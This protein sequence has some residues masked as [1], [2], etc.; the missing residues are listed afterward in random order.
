MDFVGG[1]QVTTMPSLILSKNSLQN[2]TLDC[3]SLGIHYQV[4]TTDNITTLRRW[5]GRSGPDTYVDIG[6]WEHRIF[7]KNT[8][9]LRG[10][11]EPVIVSELFTQTSSK[12]SGG[13]YL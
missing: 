11:S 13:M 8:F 7:K 1:T 2:T 10:E 9:K 5:D 6:Q 4:S 3:D 12:W